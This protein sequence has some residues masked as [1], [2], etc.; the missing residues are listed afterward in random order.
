[1]VPEHCKSGE[2][3]LRQLRGRAGWLHSPLSALSYEPILDYPAMRF[4]AIPRCREME[5]AGVSGGGGFGDG[6]GDGDGYGGG[7][8]PLGL[9]PSTTPLSRKP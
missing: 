3:Q 8:S 6:F 2:C 7:A 9:R 4:R 5:A 1:M